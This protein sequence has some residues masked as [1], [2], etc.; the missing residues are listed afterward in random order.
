MSKDLCI[1]C[2][3]DLEYSDKFE[4]HIL[5]SHMMSYGR[6]Y[7]YHKTIGESRC[8][9]C[10]GRVYPISPWY[11]MNCPCEKCNNS[12]SYYEIVLNKVREV[13]SIL[14]TNDY[15]RLF[16]LDSNLRERLNEFDLIKISSN[17]Q[18][19]LEDK[20]GIDKINLFEIRTEDGKCPYIKSD[21]SNV[22]ICKSKFNI[23]ETEL[24]KYD[25]KDCY[26]ININGNLFELY[27]P[28]KCSYHNNNH[29]KY[30]IL[31]RMNNPQSAKKL[32]MSSG[33]CI[34]FYNT[35]FDRCKSVLR[36]S[37][38][39]VD[40]YSMSL[41]K[42]ELDYLKFYIM[43]NKNLLRIITN[44]LY[45]LIKNSDTVY[46]YCFLLNKIL[47]NK[48]GKFDMIIDWTVNNRMMSSGKETLN[49]SIL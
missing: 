44:V 36:I 26:K 5:N 47:I 43:S 14:C 8:D 22:L 18:K 24:N 49:I 17:L 37:K 41:T 12:K 39:G 40:T 46:D 25:D 38:C 9:N 45:E 13:Y 31:N 7:E 27:L 4:F 20:V 32:L 35:N 2:G 21:F 10:E 6:Y 30:N 11:G 15:I 3:E 33:E 16:V 23:L 1:L 34:K 19:L 42:Y 29:Y 48:L 28:E